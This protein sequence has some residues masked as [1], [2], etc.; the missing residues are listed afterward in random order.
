MKEKT[1]YN[2]EGVFFVGRTLYVE[3]TNGDYGGAQ[4]PFKRA[5]TMAGGHDVSVIPTAPAI[6]G[7]ARDTTAAAGDEL[8]DQGDRRE[9]D[10]HYVVTSRNQGHGAL[11]LS[12][13]AKGSA[14][15]WTIATG[16]W[17]LGSFAF[18]A[19]RARV[20]YADDAG[21]LAITDLNFRGTTTLPVAADTLLDVTADGRL[22][23][24]VADG[25]C[26]PG[27]PRARPQ[28]ICFVR[29]P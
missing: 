15:E 25:P 27:L 3:G 5:V 2:I 11:T 19:P 22:A 6:P 20:L 7:Q 14:H 16:S 10:D 24:Y 1:E 18:D 26:D 21:K 9:E 13:A 12:A 17:N 29:L 4:T 23:A 28:T 8:S